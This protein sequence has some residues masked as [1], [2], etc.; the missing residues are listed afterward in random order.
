V[1]ASSTGRGSERPAA[2]KRSSAGSRRAAEPLDNVTTIYNELRALIL[3]GQLPPGARVAERAVVARTGHSRTP[4][5]SALHRLQQE[6]LVASLGR[7]GDQRLIVT[8]LTAADGHEVFL[9]E[10]HLEGLAAGEAAA[11]PVEKRTRLARRLREVNHDFAAAARSGTL[12]AKLFALDNL[13][14][15]TFV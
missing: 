10:G 14:H 6:G 12:S 2:K 15:E 3:S 5:R 9:L 8:P 1:T 7:P 13:F 4:V 11:L